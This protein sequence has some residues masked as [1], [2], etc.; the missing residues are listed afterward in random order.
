MSAPEPIAHHP[1]PERAT[2]EVLW[3]QDVSATVL[4]RGRDG[5]LSAGGLQVGIPAVS[6]LAELGQGATARRVGLTELID[7]AHEPP[8]GLEPGGSARATFA[9]LDLAQRSVSEGLL[10]PQLQYGGRAWL[11]Y[12]GATID[13]SVQEALDLIA[14]AMPPVC[15]GAF[16]GDADALVH[17]LYACAVDQVARDR[18]RATGVRLGNRLIR[19]RPSA[20]EL[21]L[22]GLTS[23]EPELPPHAGLGAL[24]RRL[25][26]WV[27][28]GLERRSSAPWLLSL[29]LD[30]REEPEADGSSAVVLELWLQAADDPTLVLPTSLLH[31]G[32][33]AVFGFLRSADPRIAVHRQLGLIEPVLAEGGLA[34]DPLEPTTVVLGDDD[35]R[36]VLRTAIPRL[37][38]IGVPVLLPRNWVSSS[39]RLRVNLT[40]TS[41][42]GRSSGLLTTDALA[43]FDW[44][45]AIGE[46]TLTEAELAELAAA[47][48]PLIRIQGRWH[49]LRRSEVEKALQF[50][51]RRREGSV[52]DLVRAVSGVEL[53]DA[54]LELGEVTL[55]EALGALLSGGDERR[56][57]PLG[58]PAAMTQP[59]FPFQERGHGWLRLLGD[60]GIGAILADD[61]GLG[62]T[63]Q[64]IAML[65]SEREQ[66]G[67]EAFGPTLVVC[68][69]SV[70][71]QWAREIERFAPS[72]RVHLHHGGERLTGDELADVAHASDVVITSYDIA[73]RDVDTLATVQWD[74]LLL[75]EAQDVKNP[76]TKRARALRR[77]DARRTLAMTGTPIE[78]RLDELWAIMDIVN[79]GLLGSRE[80]FQRTFARPIEA[81]GDSRSLERLRAMVQ[82]FILR[83]PKDSPEVELELPEITVTKEY[84]RLTLE[85]ASL[86]RA[87]VDRWMPRIE[88]HEKS[89]GRRGAV[90]AML[91]Q[92]KQVCNHPEMVLATG[93]PLA[94]RS[95]K[96][97]RLV[98]LL[99]A[100][101]RE[102]KALVFTQYPGFDRIVPHLHERLGREIGFFH[103][104]LPARQRDELVAAFSEPGGPSV[105]VISIRA[106]GRGLNLPAANHVFHF[107][108]WWNPAVE[109]QATDRAYRF[110]QHKDVFVHSLICT[111][112]L[113]ERIDELLDSKRELAEKVVAGRADDWLGEL[114]L[115]AIRAAVALSDT[116]VEE[117][118]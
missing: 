24:E 80:R 54:G 29:R 26:D 41:V 35:V 87:T 53:E 83:R 106:G 19:N 60:M 97:E 73:T 99:E 6:D 89:F 23:T 79:P 102:D 17:D 104:G 20:P 76:A 81:H 31:D 4:A 68:P 37:E 25:T 101:P 117:A 14:A 1:I 18:L 86:Y 118:A 66:F 55:D 13:E 46:T 7:L 107:D 100:M 57:E 115:D 27:D 39:S 10:H 85:Q 75:D 30:E 116:S 72:L 114:D 98:E 92:L 77:L 65:T 15:A 12:W 90:L 93:R 110:G 70:T 67:A 62:K 113:E 58:T 22:D 38:E 103:G 64:A 59:L 95:G 78:N 63:V 69:M 105:L 112:T 16:D 45:L 32:G 43:R 42:P 44:K 71:R 28:R 47:K 40:A 8:P 50:L 88:E 82:P 74:R 111:A 34:F 5:S 52:V 3:Q 51:D 96:L 49:A 108:R 109:Q 84:C 2:L 21:F 36:F 9:V 61:M 48:E 91:S 94:G 56:Y 11:A 33:D